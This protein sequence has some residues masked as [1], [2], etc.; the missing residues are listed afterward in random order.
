MDTHDKFDTIIVMLGT[1]ELK[2]A[3]N[4]T[5][6]DIVQMI[7]K[8]VCFIKNYKTKKVSKVDKLKFKIDSGN[9]LFIQIMRK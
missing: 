6:E 3:L 1:N 8:Y 7:D 5:A 4:N 9:G 2:Y